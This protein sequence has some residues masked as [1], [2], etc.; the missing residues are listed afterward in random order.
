[1]RPIVDRTA[2]R[3]AGF[4]VGNGALGETVPDLGQLEA[5]W[6][7]RAKRGPMDPAERATL[8]ARGLVG[9]ANRGGRR[10]VTIVER[11]AFDRI[12]ATLGDDVH[13]VMRRANLMVS[14]IRLADSRGRILAVG[15]CRIRVHGETRPCERMDEAFAGL[16]AALRSDWGGGIS[17]VIEEG[18]EI[19]VGDP[20]RWVE[21]S[22]ERAGGA[23]GATR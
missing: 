16:R 7:K 19:V 3:A 2:L 12:R 18:G 6:I 8:D 13:P 14:G 11:E 1:M 22:D 9:N 10:A 15:P 23:D 21:R 4:L 17:G 20:V 5:I